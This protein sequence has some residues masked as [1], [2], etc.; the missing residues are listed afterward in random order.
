V[1][2]HLNAWKLEDHYIYLHVQKSYQANW[3]L[4]M[5]AFMEAYH[6]GDTHPQVAPA[7]GDVNSQYDVHG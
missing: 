3:K 6:V 5:K 1:V 4:T 7:N 2:E